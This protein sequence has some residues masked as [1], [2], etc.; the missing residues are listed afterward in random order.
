MLKTTLSELGALESGLCALLPAES[1][2]CAQSTSRDCSLSRQEL[3]G[4]RLLCAAAGS[5]L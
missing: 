3:P 1:L 4:Q 5:V 2:G